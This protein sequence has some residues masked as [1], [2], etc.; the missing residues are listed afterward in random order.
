MK[1]GAEARLI[2]DRMKQGLPQLHQ[3][4]GSLRDGIELPCR[5]DYWMDEFHIEVELGNNASGEPRLAELARR[6]LLEKFPEAKEIHNIRDLAVWQHEALISLSIHPHNRQE[7]GQAS[8]LERE[9]HLDRLPSQLKE[10]GN[11]EQAEQWRR[12]RRELIKAFAANACAGLHKLDRPTEPGPRSLVLGASIYLALLACC[13]GIVR[14]SS[15]VISPLGNIL[16]TL[17]SLAAFLVL[18]MWWRTGSRRTRQEELACWLNM[19]LTV[20]HLDR[21]LELNEQERV[22]ERALL[23]RKVRADR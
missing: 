23:K 20:R 19:F 6:M 12:P 9:L 2:L 15:V 16:A 10:P 4:E 7:A 11:G 17:F 1:K 8:E 21:M 3:R 5:P 22:I 18:L 13:F 14:I